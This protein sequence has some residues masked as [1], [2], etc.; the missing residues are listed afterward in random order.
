ML[1]YNQDQFD[2]NNPNGLI[3]SLPKR[4]QGVAGRLTYDY[5]YRYLA[6][7]NFGYNGSENFAEGHRFGF[8]PSFALGYTIS[9]ENYFKSL[10]NIIT[11]LKIRG[12]W[13]LVGNDQIGSDR[14]IYMSDIIL[15]NGDMS[16]TTGK[17]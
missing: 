7:F 13:G 9:R 4:K 14:Y 11:N 10:N 8:F 17:D 15:Q 16:F 2:V 5:D 6:E 3:A 1:L 12:S